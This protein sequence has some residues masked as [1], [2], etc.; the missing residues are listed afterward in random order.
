MFLSFAQ[1][2]IYRSNRYKFS[3]IY[4]NKYAYLKLNELKSKLISGQKQ[5]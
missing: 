4:K 3:F 5:T 1:M 2:S